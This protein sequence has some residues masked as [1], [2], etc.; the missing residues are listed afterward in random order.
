M[1]PQILPQDK[2]KRFTEFMK[3]PTQGLSP[4]DKEIM[5]FFKTRFPWILV[6]E[7]S[8]STTDQDHLQQLNRVVKIKWWKPFDEQK[9]QTS[10]NSSTF[11]QKQTRLKELNA[12]KKNLEQAYQDLDHNQDSDLGGYSQDPFAF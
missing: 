12:L 7:F 11:A 4:V 1:D 3:T 5:F 6:W 2:L 10:P 9:T 8:K